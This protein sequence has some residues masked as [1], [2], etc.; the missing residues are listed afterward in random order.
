MKDMKRGLFPLLLILIFSAVSGCAFQYTVPEKIV[1]V[2]AAGLSAAKIPLKAAILLPDERYTLTK[3][4]TDPAVQSI[5]VTLVVPFG[6]LMKNASQAIFP[7]I[8]EEVSIVTG[9]AS[10]V[11]GAD[12]LYTPSI[13]DFSFDYGAQSIAQ[14]TLIVRMHLN[15]KVTDAAGNS[16]YVDETMT[17]TQKVYPST[18]SESAYLDVQAD[19]MASAV[20][21]VLLK[22]ARGL[23]EAGEIRMLAKSKTGGSFGTPQPAGA[24]PRGTAAGQPEDLASIRVKLRDAFEKGA[25]SAEQLTRAL[26]EGGRISRSK[27]LDAFLEDKIDAQKFGELY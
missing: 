15:G 10:N 16:V 21:D 18:F 5:Q 22:A 19:I 13:K 7:L 25:I 9:G 27:I 23:A 12:L 24:A 17:E 2:D 6:K 8:F 1:P 14:Q 11:S 3:T 4:R 20:N 26:E